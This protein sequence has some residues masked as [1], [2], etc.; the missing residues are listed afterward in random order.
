MLKKQHNALHGF[1]KPFYISTY[2]Q[3]TYWKA[4]GAIGY[5]FLF[6]CKCQSVCTAPN[7]RCWIH[8]HEV[9][10]WWFVQ[11]HS[12]QWLAGGHFVEVTLGVLI[13]FLH[14]LLHCWS[15]WR[16]TRCPTCYGNVSIICKHYR[17]LG[18]TK[19]CA[20]WWV[21]MTTVNSKFKCYCYVKRN[22]IKV[23]GLQCHHCLTSF[24]PLLG[25]QT[26]TLDILL[27]ACIFLVAHKK[28]SNLINFYPAVQIYILHCKSISEKIVTKTYKINVAESITCY[29]AAGTAA[30]F[31]SNPEK[32]ERIG[33]ME[34][35]PSSL[36]F[37]PPERGTNTKKTE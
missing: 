23:K 24:P 17:N 12:H 15:E 27:A 33:W 30:G 10:F 13:M 20:S 31:S 5:A 14:A 6:Y 22:H 21:Q 29:S 37:P 8:P 26:S 2:V 34:N 36:Y 19:T 25:H 28:K 7:R 3:W 18:I 9:C 16:A 35:K 1:L 11:R 4:Q 32:D